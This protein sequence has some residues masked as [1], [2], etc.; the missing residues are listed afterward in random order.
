MPTRK[1]DKAALRNP[2]VV[3]GHHDDYDDDDHDDH[4][5]DDHDDHDDLEVTYK[6]VGGEGD[7]E[8]IQRSGALLGL[9]REKITA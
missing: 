6:G 5:D 3:S 7:C 4:D 8:S 9:G 1:E 2:P